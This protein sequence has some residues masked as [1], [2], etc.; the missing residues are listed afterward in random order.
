MVNQLKRSYFGGCFLNRF[1]YFG[2][3]RIVSSC[4]YCLGEDGRTEAE[5]HVD[6]RSSSLENT[7]RLY[8]RRG[9]AI[10]GLIDLEVLQRALC[11][12]SPVLVCRYVD[13]A[14][15][16]RLCS[17]SCH[18]SCCCVKGSSEVGLGKGWGSLVGE[19]GK[20]V[21]FGVG[22]PQSCSCRLACDSKGGERRSSRS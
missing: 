3:C 10:L 16:I 13:L 18:C 14:E 9:H 17:G 1:A 7:K 2:V 20:G 22:R 11:L 4:T 21:R 12:C 19:G 8:D 5:L 15:G 6:G